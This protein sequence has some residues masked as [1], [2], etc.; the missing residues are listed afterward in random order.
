MEFLILFIFYCC[1]DYIIIK[2]LGGMDIRG[3]IG[4]YLL[5]CL[6]IEDINEDGLLE[7]ENIY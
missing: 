6:F 1:K 4:I 3:Y 2:L 7:K 5:I